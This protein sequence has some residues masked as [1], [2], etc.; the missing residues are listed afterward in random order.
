M[1]SEIPGHFGAFE[2]RDAI[3][4]L[5]D[6]LEVPT[7]LIPVVRQAAQGPCATADR[8]SQIFVVGVGQAGLLQ[9][10]TEELIWPRDPEGDLF[11]DLPLA[12]LWDPD[13]WYEAAASWQQEDPAAWVAFT[14]RIAVP[15]ANRLRLVGAWTHPKPTLP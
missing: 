7:E 12:G 10:D 2:I 13:S 6:G 1:D 4:Q 8:G 5:A 9:I 14:W 11:D 3:G 15:L